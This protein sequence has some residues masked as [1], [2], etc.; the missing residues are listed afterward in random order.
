[1]DIYDGLGLMALKREVHKRGS[2][3]YPYAALSEQH[4]QMHRHF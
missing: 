2:T 3:P 1:M 4:S